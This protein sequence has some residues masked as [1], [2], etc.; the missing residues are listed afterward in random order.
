MKLLVKILAILV[1]HTVYSQSLL[2]GNHLF[3][4]NYFSIELG[5]GLNKSKMVPVVGLDHLTSKI[6]TI[7]QMKFKYQFNFQN[8]YG[9]ILNAGF[10]KLNLKVGDNFKN[11]FDYFTG[12]GQRLNNPFAKFSWGFNYHKLMGDQFIFKT[13]VGSGFSIFSSAISSGL[14]TFA[15]PSILRVVT[16]YYSGNSSPKTFLFFDIGVDKIL[17][18]KDLIG[19]NLSYEHYFKS[20]LVGNY[21]IQK[22]PE[23]NMS[24]GN[25]SN[26]LNNLSLSVNYTFTQY[27]KDDLKV[28]M[29]NEDGISKRKAQKV[30]KKNKRFVDPNSIFISAG[31]GL[32]LNKNSVS[33][34]AGHLPSTYGTG[35]SL[36]YMMVEIGLTKNYFFEIGLESSDYF[37][38]TKLFNNSIFSTSAFTATKWNIGISK[39]LTNPISNRNYLNIHTGFSISVQPYTGDKD[40]GE[41]GGGYSQTSEYYKLE[42]A[43]KFKSYVFP[44]VYLA[45]EK[46]FQITKN[47]YTCLKYKYDQGFV[48]VL[49]TD[50]HILKDLMLLHKMPHLK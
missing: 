1:G 49:S 4:R 20:S 42:H 50:I 39:R 18:N 31:Y 34:A 2:N 44:T 22:F 8:K 27:K 17:K 45:I 10:G 47:V 41:I 28:S 7:S 46:D 30:Y 25:F 6:S 40:Y 23:N 19:L 43:S 5:T 21:S 14:Y 48:S 24:N 12:F 35:S 29:A 36:G 33:D 16:T 9:I 37:S 15:D 38:S 13:S 32:F 11:D 3:D 26:S